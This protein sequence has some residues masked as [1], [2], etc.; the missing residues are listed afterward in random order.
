MGG[1]QQEFEKLLEKAKESFEQAQKE[2]VAA[3][4][5]QQAIKAKEDACKEDSRKAS[6]MCEEAKKELDAHLME[7]QEIDDKD[8]ALQV[9]FEEAKRKADDLGRALEQS[10]CQQQRILEAIDA[11]E[12]AYKNAKRCVCVCMCVYIPIQPSIPPIFSV[13][14]PFENSAKELRS[15]ASNAE[16]KITQFKKNLQDSRRDIQRCD[17]A[18]QSYK[19][20]PDVVEVVPLD[21][22]PTQRHETP[23]FK[24]C[25]SNWVPWLPSQDYPDGIN[26][27]CHS[28]I[29]IQVIHKVADGVE[30]GKYW[31][32]VCV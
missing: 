10:T 21:E 16:L 20:V 18:I 4:N 5:D 17:F 25:K 7:K 27:E 23:P 30:T 13:L 29:S 28:K 26:P 15:D 8:Q 32:G 6:A 22:Q 2:L 14:E 3:E 19:E 11:A 31:C 9:A 1:I 12:G 24:F